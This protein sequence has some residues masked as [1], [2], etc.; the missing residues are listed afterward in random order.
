MKRCLQRGFLVLALFALLAGTPSAESGA[1]FETFGYG[2]MEALVKANKGKVVMINFFATWCPP[3]RE[4]IPGLINIRKDIG[5]DKLVLIGASVDEDMA[6]LSAY[7]EK[8]QF[9]Y[10]I[11]KA[12]MD[13][14]Q[15][16]GVSGIP[17]MLIFDGAGEVIGNAAGL[18]PEKDLREFLQK[19]MESR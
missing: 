6:A 5:E 8:T 13:L 12:G 1:E 11:K 14:V 2:Q 7:A 3:C 9:N 4:E 16:A 10:P 19:H 15:A 18:V 17:H